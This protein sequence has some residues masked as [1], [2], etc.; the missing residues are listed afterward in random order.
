LALLARPAEAASPT[1]EIAHLD[2]EINAVTADY[3]AHAVARAS[4]DHAGALIVITNTPG[5]VS[6]SMDDIVTDLLNAP[7]PVAVYVAPAGARAASA[8]LFIAQSAD[9]VAMAPGTNIGSAH[10]VTG[11]GGDITGDLGR[12]VLNDAVARIRN[13]AS[14]HRRN[15]D[16][17]ERAVRDS[18]NIG[19]DEATRIGVAD[20]QEPSLTALLAALDQRTSSR[21]GREVTFHTANAARLDLPVSPFQQLLLALIDPNVAYLL[22]LVAVFGLIAEVSAPGAI[23]PG[24]I[25][26]LSALLALV[27][28]STLPI[29]LAGILLIGFAF[30]LFIADVKAPT[31]GVLTAGALI[32]L[33]LGSAFLFDTG[34]VDLG[35]D[36]RVV[37]G[38]TLAVAAGLIFVVRKA[39]HA[40][41]PHESASTSAL[42]GSLGEARGPL[43]PDGQ[44]FVA[45][46]LWP[47]VS[48]S[49][50]IDSGEPVRVIAQDKR[51]L[52]VEA[53]ARRGPV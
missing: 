7:I 37:V 12:K 9:V 36:W 41:S 19:A 44:V 48:A 10:P 40:R 11:S 5:G 32:S 13:L 1:V 38:A 18:V 26:G 35:I 24:V 3:V 4:A 43:S 34:P 29:N 15:A 27:A 39:A 2:G 21:P 49:G 50:A 14:L 6:T 22:M 25:G 42:V 23:V 28:L 8:G 53:A 30:L 45:G 47:A 51:S 46:A 33:L 20:L 52:R 16:W 31:H 17:C